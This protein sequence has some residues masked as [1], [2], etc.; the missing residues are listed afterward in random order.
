V[1]GE[2]SRIHEVILV[3]TEVSR[4]GQP[5]GAAAIATKLALRIGGKRVTIRPAGDSPFFSDLTPGQLRIAP[6]NSWQA[7]AASDPPEGAAVLMVPDRPPRPSAEDERPM[8]S[9]PEARI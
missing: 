6:I 7:L 4:D 3:E 8:A 2:A 5:D 9:V 1:I